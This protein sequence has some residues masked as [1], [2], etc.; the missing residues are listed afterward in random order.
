MFIRWTHGLL[1][2]SDSS[3]RDSLASA[4]AAKEGPEPS[5][6]KES[7]RGNIG[8]F[9]V[10]TVL[11]TIS[12][13]LTGG[14]DA[15][16]VY[17]V[18]HA[19]A[20]VLGSFASIWSAVFLSFTLFGGWFSDRYERKTSLLLG[21]G[22]TLLNPL[23]YAVAPDWQLLLVANFLGAVGTA[24]ANPAYVALLVTSAGRDRRAESIAV[25]NTVSSIANAVVPPLAA[26]AVQSLGGL[27]RLRLMFVLQFLAGIGIWY[28][29]KRH[30]APVGTVRPGNGVHRESIVKQMMGDMRDVW[31]LS[32][33]RKA[34]GWVY[35]AA[36]APLAW[37][38]VGPFWT[39]Y[40][41]EA[42]NSPIYVV[43]LLPTV[44]SLVH[45][46]AE[47]PL[48][49]K[50]SSVGRRRIIVAMRPFTYSSLV[51]LLAAATL[52]PD[53]SPFLPIV[54][55]A[56]LALGESSGPAWTAAATEVMP[57]E[58]QGK[59]DAFRNFLSYA[60]AIPAGLAGGLLWDIDR[61]LPF[62]F[63]L[64]VDGVFRFPALARMVPETLVRFPSPHRTH[65][66]TVVIY[67]LS[68]AGLTSTAKEMRDAVHAE[69]VDEEWVKRRLQERRLEI[70]RT[71]HRPHILISEKDILERGISTI[72]EEA[73]KPLIV[74]G[75]VAIYAAREADKATLVLL[76][77]PKY[78]RARRLAETTKKP[79]FVALHEIEQR[80]RET[81]R[82]VKRVLRADM[83]ALPPFDVAINTER[84][85][86]ELVR[87]IL[88]AIDEH[89]SETPS[90]EGE[91]REGP[92]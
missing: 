43:G 10:R 51:V 80:D 17:Q 5:L 20:I 14:L 75:K 70:E 42:C 87:K 47:I 23:I 27:E 57:P 50:A 54:A 29:T 32:R 49:R 66:Q 60:I 30:L 85:S 78:E 82:L 22:I 28:Y 15:L 21:T 81:Q 4:T 7:L 55:W 41:Y 89:R 68:E 92:V 62:A 44:A 48:A 19:D 53:V 61:R 38:V 69:I 24:V 90:E 74:E 9:A 91:K 63:A 88:R 1:A 86:P 25:I 13:G 64:V 84:I 40:A 33:E 11:L 35:I 59:W 77:A 37:N 52:K 8:V 12:G 46:A 56:L 36:T 83:R 76:V 6:L 79:D 26:L 45:I 2:K 73:R 34:T 18:L 31:K 71:I 72:L 65:G 39:L 3:E 67:G 58:V 16:Y